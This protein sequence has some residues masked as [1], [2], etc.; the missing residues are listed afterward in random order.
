MK[1][2]NTV[3]NDLKRL[4]NKIPSNNIGIV[5]V[6]MAAGE[7]VAALPDHIKNDPSTVV[8]VD[9]IINGQAVDVR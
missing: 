6:D 9:N 2:I 8:I 1:I 7:T 4:K 3:K 5:V